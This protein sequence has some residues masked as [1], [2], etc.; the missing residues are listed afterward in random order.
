MEK[1]MT[2]RKKNILLIIFIFPITIIIGMLYFVKLGGYFILNKAETGVYINDIK[3]SPELPNRFYEIYNIIYPDA[4]DN[5]AWEHFLNKTL[6]KNDSPCACEEVI[7]ISW[8]PLHTKTSEVILLTSL[9]EDYASQKECLRYYAS[10]FVFP[11][12]IIGV[13]N[14]AV[15]YFHKQIY[16][17]SDSEFTE[18]IL[19]MKNPFIYNKKRYPNRVRADINNILK[20]L[21]NS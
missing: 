1:E 9:T 15:Q 18:L 19:I 16:F 7:Y 6:E 13:R 3:N 4:L 21:H 14:A 17:L 2:K 8:H 5:N 10:K 11:N 12:K 20:K